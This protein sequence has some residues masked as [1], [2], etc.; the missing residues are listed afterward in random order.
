[1]TSHNPGGYQAAAIGVFDVDGTS[2]P[3]VFFDA[4]SQSLMQK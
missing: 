2:L 3:Q 1:V 4:Q